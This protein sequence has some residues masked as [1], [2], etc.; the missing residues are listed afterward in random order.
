MKKLLCIP[1]LFIVAT[2]TGCF[3]ARMYYP[4]G[5]ETF[6][7]FPGIGELVID[8]KMPSEKFLK[9]QEETWRKLTSDPKDP[10]AKQIPITATVTDTR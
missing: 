10:V 2:N 6:L 8:R 9:D 4:A 3:W 5:Q 7:W 1:L